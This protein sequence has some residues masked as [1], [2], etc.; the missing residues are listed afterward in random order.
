MQSVKSS[1]FSPLFTPLGF[2]FLYYPDEIPRPVGITPLQPLSTL[3]PLLLHRPYMA[4]P[5]PWLSLALSLLCAGTRTAWLMEVGKIHTR[6]RHYLSIYL[7]MPQCCLATHYVFSLVPSVSWVPRWVSH[8]FFSL[9]KPPTPPR[10]FQLMTL[11][12]ISLETQKQT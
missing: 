12:P 1:T 10:H 3:L 5:Q 11:F 2:S 4:K 7:H 6:T 8:M 9:C